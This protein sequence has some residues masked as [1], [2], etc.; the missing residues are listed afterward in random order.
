MATPTF[1]A[2]AC[3][4]FAAT[5]AY[6]TTQTHL[7]FKG[8]GPGCAM[9]NCT[10]AG[11]H[12]PPVQFGTATPAVGTAGGTAS[13]GHAA[14]GGARVNATPSPRAGRG[15][16]P[17]ADREKGSRPASA[18]ARGHRS[19]ARVI[20]AYRTVRRW[21]GGFLGSVTIINHSGSALPGWQLW[22]RYQRA[23]LD[24]VWG[25]RWYPPD[26]QDR[27]A[28]RVAPRPGHQVLRPRASTRFFFRVT[29][30]AGPPAGCYF[31]SARCRFRSG[32]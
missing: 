29:G 6:G 13:A 12:K 4:V 10:A 7:V 23:R 3:I 21:P 19:D 30:N 24:Q 1:F 26:P 20:I 5:L 16:G 15:S 28:A 32:R 27:G 17:G 31:N 8:I 25:A 2:G 11:S 9:A 22:L 18:A 14:G